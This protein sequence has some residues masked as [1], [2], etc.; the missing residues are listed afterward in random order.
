MNKPVS[1]ATRA[2]LDAM[3]EDDAKPSPDKLDA[4]CAKLAELEELEIRKSNLEAQIEEVGKRINEIKS[5][6]IVEVFDAAGIDSL[7]LPQ[8]GNVPPYEVE[9]IEFFHAN[10]PEDKKPEAW[11]WMKQTKN[12]D[13]VKTQFSV[14]FGLGDATKAKKFEAGLKK[15]TKE[16][17]KKQSVPWNTLTAFVKGEFKAKRPLSKKVMGILGAT[18][19]RVA[20]V[21]KQKVEKK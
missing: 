21:I 14:E 7:G 11:A 4:A 3:S 1:A 8:R 9:I 12:E 19:G 15:L 17:D 10:I 5:K 20:K 18:N 6:E 16:Y 2:L 13:L